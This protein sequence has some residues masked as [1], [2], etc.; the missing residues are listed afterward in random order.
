[1][2]MDVSM[3]PTYTFSVTLV[4]ADSN[5]QEFLQKDYSASFSQLLQDPTSPVIR[6]AITSLL[7][8]LSQT[9]QGRKGL[10]QLPHCQR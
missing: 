5:V 1:M 2:Y 6:S 7:H 10:L 9:K 4:S 3:G 8:Q